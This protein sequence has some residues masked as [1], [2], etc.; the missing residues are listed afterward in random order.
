MDDERKLLLSINSGSGLNNDE[1]LP[2]GILGS[3]AELPLSPHI[4]EGSDVVAALKGRD[5][6]GKLLVTLGP[7][8]YNSPVLVSGSLVL[9]CWE[10]GLLRRLISSEFSLLPLKSGGLFTDISRRDVLSWYGFL[11]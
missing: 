8:L 10:F 5:T 4:L 9:E 11:T 2:V 1:G 3:G 7:V 6:A